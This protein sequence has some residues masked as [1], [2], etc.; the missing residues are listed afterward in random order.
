MLN[1]KCL[2]KVSNHQVYD[3]NGISPQ[4]LWHGHILCMKKDGPADIL[5][6]MSSPP[7]PLPPLPTAGKDSQGDCMSPFPA[8][9]RNGL[10][11]IFFMTSCAL[12]ETKPAG[13]DFQLTALWLTDDDESYLDFTEH[14]SARP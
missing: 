2:D 12:P 1:I 8:N 13:D 6:C 9:S 5:L 11:Q 7:P 3:L 14:F 4:V 10:M